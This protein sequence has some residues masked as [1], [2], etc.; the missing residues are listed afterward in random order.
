M[1]IE[2]ERQCNPA[3]Q[4][5]EKCGNTCVVLERCTNLKEFVASDMHPE[6]YTEAIRVYTDLKLIDWREQEEENAL[7]RPRATVARPVLHQVNILRCYSHFWEI[8]K[9]T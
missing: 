7:L 2:R 3:V 4:K 6:M 5:L 9:T 8:L 1:S